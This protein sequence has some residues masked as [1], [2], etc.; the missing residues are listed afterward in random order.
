MLGANVEVR[1]DRRSD[2]ANL[3]AGES[4]SGG[5]EIESVKEGGILRLLQ[6]EK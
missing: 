6:S 3:F 5:L 2:G 4:R 1:L